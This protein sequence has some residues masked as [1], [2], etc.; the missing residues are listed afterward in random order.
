MPKPDQ[1]LAL[2]EARVS[3]RGGAVDYFRHYLTQAHNVAERIPPAVK[4]EDAADMFVRWLY[5]EPFQESDDM[6]F[7]MLTPDA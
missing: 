3:E 6:L 4:A 5:D 2:V 1:F 7:D